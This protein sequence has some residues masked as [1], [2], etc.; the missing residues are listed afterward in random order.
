ML[1]YYSII[2]LRN[3]SV[4]IFIVIENWIKGG[5]SNL[6]LIADENHYRIS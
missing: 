6:T 3:Y 2:M 5:N 4:D 1:Q